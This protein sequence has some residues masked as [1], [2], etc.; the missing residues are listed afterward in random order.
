MMRGAAVLAL[1]VLGCEN[2]PKKAA[3]ASVPK[4]RAEALQAP[5]GTPAPSA[6]VPASAPSGRASAPS[7]AR[8][9]CEGQLAKPGR[10]LPKKPLSRRAGPGFTLLPLGTA[11]KWTW[12]NLWAAWC[13]PC[14]EE[15][16]RLYGF[17][18]RLGREG[19][20]MQLSF[21]SLDDDERQ[22]D[23]FMAAQLS[24]NG[25]K[26]TYWLREGRERDDWLAA[27]GMSGDAALPVQL[28]VDPKGKL[29]CVVNGA[30]E[31]GDFR[32]IASIVALP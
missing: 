1:L 27:I 5:P 11:A 30:V 15:I 29:R 25:I 19:H 28:L 32:E 22:L 6:T 31:D 21:I 12:V 8:K 16:P 18:A 3:M 26:G 10:D 2:D 14:K 4:E 20:P 7:G 9:L 23:E 13:A 24:E 17:V